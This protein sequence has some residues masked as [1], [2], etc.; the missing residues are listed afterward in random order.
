MVKCKIGKMPKKESK[1]AVNVFGIV[2]GVFMGGDKMLNLV[3]FET[4]EELCELT[5]LTEHE[6]WQKGFNLDDWE[7]GFQSEVKLH[8][9]PTKKD[10]ENGYREN[11]LIA[12]FDL[13]AHWLMSQMNAYCVGANYVFLDGKHYYTVHH[14]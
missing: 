8:K 13:P 1:I 2:D 10:I 7:I 6:L 4:E 3:V 9:T 14:A 11:E 12:L 5:G